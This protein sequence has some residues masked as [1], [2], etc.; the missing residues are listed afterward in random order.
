MAHRI[1]A[2]IEQVKA[3]TLNRSRYRAPGIAQRPDQLTD[4]DHSMLPIRE[5]SQ[6]I[7]SPMA[8]VSPSFVSH[9]GTKE[10]DTPSLPPPSLFFAPRP[11]SERKKAA[12]PR[13]GGSVKRLTLRAR[14]LR[15][16]ARTGS[17]LRPGPWRPA[18]ARFRPGAG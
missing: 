17:A 7:M 14:P 13:T 4:R 9:S 10:G 12:G 8:E 6:R 3:T 16:P 11:R 18:P 1:H 2:S 15:R 5:F